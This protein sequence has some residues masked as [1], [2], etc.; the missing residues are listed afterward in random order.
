MLPDP[1]F[2][3]LVA[4]ET[5]KARHEETGAP[6]RP[7]PRVDLVQLARARLNREIV[8]Q[9]LHEPRKEPLVVERRRAVGLLLLTARIVQEHEIQ[10]RAVAELEA[11]ELAVAND[12]ETGLARRR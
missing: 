7:Q 1:G 8:N 12:R 2:G 4:A 9:A 10:I 11:A 6:A 5:V 3:L